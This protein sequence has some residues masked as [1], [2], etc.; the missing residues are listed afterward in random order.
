MTFCPF[1]AFGKEKNYNYTVT[2][3]TCLLLYVF[4]A[5]KICFNTIFF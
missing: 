2:V 1:D 5:I 4:G 3:M